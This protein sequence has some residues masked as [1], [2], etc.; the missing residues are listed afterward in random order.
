MNR[1]QTTIRLPAELKEQLQQ[2]ADKWAS[3]N[4]SRYKD[5]NR[6]KR[7][8]IQSAIKELKDS[9]CDSLFARRLRN[10][11]NSHKQD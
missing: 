11:C 10:L 7:L 6:A 5:S 1:E 3:D 4:A 8:F 2:E 9:K